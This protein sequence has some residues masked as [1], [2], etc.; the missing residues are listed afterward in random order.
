[1]S[2][3]KYTLTCQVPNVTENFE[4]V[5]ILSFLTSLKFKIAVILNKTFRKDFREVTF[6]KLANRKKYKSER[7]ELFLKNDPYQLYYKLC[8]VDFQL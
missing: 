6:V 4:S 7:K 3:S 8:R 1:M 5:T 2:I